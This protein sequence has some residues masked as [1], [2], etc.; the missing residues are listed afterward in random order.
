MTPRVHDLLARQLS[1]GPH[2]VANDLVFGF[3]DGTPEDLKPATGRL[4]ARFTSLFR[5]AS[6]EDVTEHDLRHEATCRWFEMRSTDG[7]WLYRTEEI[8]VIMGWAPGSKM[9]LRY[10][11]FR[12]EDLA[13]RMWPSVPG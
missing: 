8:N 7:N 5:Y 3:W 6:L 1:S 11:N 12:A 2:A 9:A 10:A 4:S 13:T